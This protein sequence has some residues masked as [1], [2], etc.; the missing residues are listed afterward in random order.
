MR[1]VSLKTEKKEILEK[2]IIYVM[3]RS[4]TSKKLIE[5]AQDYLD[6]NNIPFKVS[7]INNKIYLNQIY[8]TNNSQKSM[9]Y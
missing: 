7:I 2:L 9:H 3:W 8:E 6:H 5:T 4:F 1:V